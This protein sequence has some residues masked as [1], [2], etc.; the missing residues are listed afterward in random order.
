VKRAG[1]KEVSGSVFS[2][3]AYT[4]PVKARFRFAFAFGVSSGI[5]STASIHPTNTG[6]FGSRFAD[7]ATSFEYYRITDMNL[8]L[9]PSAAGSADMFVLGYQPGIPSTYATSAQTALEMP[10]A[11]LQSR[12]S[13]VPVRCNI[14][15]KMLLG[16]E[17]VKW[18]Y[19]KVGSNDPSLV[20]QGIFA[21]G[22]YYS[23]TYNCIAVLEYEVELCNPVYAAYNDEEKR[24]VPSIERPIFNPNP[25]P[26]PITMGPCE[27]RVV[28][29][30]DD[31]IPEMPQ[32][33]SMSMP[34]LS[35]KG[36]LTQRR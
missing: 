12:T 27:E 17:S 31:A 8:T 14:S 35:R 16:D 20:Y 21:W 25:E 4:R 9:M 22:G 18:W 10:V 36:S 5:G 28:I 15:R 6:Y 19:T 34:P 1:S 3:G 11:L 7:I 30:S 23:N 26:E 24:F 2:K 32:A 13:T 33:R 29:V